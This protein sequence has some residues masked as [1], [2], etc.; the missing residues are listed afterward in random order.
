MARTGGDGERERDERD[1]HSKQQY[2]RQRLGGVKMAV[3]MRRHR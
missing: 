3:M 2:M 1:A